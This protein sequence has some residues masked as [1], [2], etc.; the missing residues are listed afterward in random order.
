MQRKK[1]PL[2]PL[3]E[4]VLL[5]VLVL[6]GIFLLLSAFI[7]FIANPWGIMWGVLIGSALYYVHYRG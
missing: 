1:K 4:L 7:G 2:N 5:I 6:L 3:V